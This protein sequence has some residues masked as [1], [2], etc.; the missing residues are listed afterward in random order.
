MQRYVPGHDHPADAGGGLGGLDALVQTPG[1]ENCFQ[2][3]VIDL[4]D[5]LGRGVERVD[6]H[7][8]R[9]GFQDGKIGQHELRAVGHADADP[10]TFADAEAAQLRGQP[11]GSIGNFPVGGGFTLE[12]QADAFRAQPGGFV[13]EMEDRHGGIIEACRHTGIVMGEPG[14][15][16][17]SKSITKSAVCVKAGLFVWFPKPTNRL[18]KGN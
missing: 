9:P 10:V 12:D 16:G 17:H 11:V 1:A 4:V 8:H 3:G 5:D 2:P 18:W 7:H 15:G 14:F 13:Q 6:G